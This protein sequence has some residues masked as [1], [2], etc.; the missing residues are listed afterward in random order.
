[1]LGKQELTGNLAAGSEG[2][3]RLLQV[4]LLEELLLDPNRQCHPERGKTARSV[5]EIGLQQALELDQRLFEKDHVID[6]VEGDLAGLQAIADRRSPGK[7]HH[8]SCA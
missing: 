4:R 2:G 8:A 7:P 3:E 5:G 1:M 6:I